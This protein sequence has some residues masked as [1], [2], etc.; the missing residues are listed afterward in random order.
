MSEE[1]EQQLNN[2]APAFVIGGGAGNNN[3]GNGS[4]KLTL[5]WPQTPALWFSQAECLYTVKNVA[6]EH[7]RYCFVVGALQHESLRLVADIVESLPY[8]V[9][10][11]YSS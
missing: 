5:F 4:V 10:A 11:V 9:A 7:T 3:G 1:Q 2:G 8:A 6:D